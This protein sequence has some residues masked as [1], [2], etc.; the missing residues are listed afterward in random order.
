MG[1]AHFEKARKKHCT[2]RSSVEPVV[3]KEKG[4]THWSKHGGI[5]ICLSRLWGYA[6]WL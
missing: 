5:N 3:Q 4:T 1:V 6:G 2:K